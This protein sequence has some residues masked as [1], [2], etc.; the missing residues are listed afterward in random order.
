MKISVSQ[1][2]TFKACR[3]EWWFKYHEMLEPV[4]RSE[5]LQIGTNYHEKIEQLN[6][7]GCFDVDCTKESAMALAYEKYI[8]PKLK[9][10]ET[11]KWLEKQITKDDIL[12]GRIDAMASDGLVVEHKTTSSDIGPVYEYNLQWNEQVLAYMYL[13]DT[14]VMHYTVC[15]KPTIRQKKNESDEE[16]FQ[17]MCEW[18]D[19]DTDSKIRTFDVMRSDE[20][21][22]AF[23]E[24]LKQTI[25]QMSSPCYRNT[26]HCSSFGVDC[27]FKSICLQ[28]DASQEYMEFKRRSET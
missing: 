20:E 1:L 27:P 15:R 10:E 23:M 18:Y 19:E 2:K 11:E 5:A 21:V 13:T 4:K 7:E 9:C 26:M 28:Y 16:F 8:L 12:V 3:R 17:R 25:P 22:N 14:R 6:N 24:E